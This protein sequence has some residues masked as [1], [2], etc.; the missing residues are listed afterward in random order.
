MVTGAQ[1]G[2]LLSMEGPLGL[3]GNALNLVSTYHLTQ[4]Q[5]ST[6]LRI[7]VHGSGEFKDE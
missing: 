3:A 6:R 1:K 2:K 7:E 4:E 5:D